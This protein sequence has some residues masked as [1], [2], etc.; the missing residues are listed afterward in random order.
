MLFGRSLIVIAICLFFEQ[1]V[2][3]GNDE[4]WLPLKF[5]IPKYAKTQ[6]VHLRILKYLN[7]L[8]FVNFK[9]GTFT[10]TTEYVFQGTSIHDFEVLWV[11]ELK[12]CRIFG[13]IFE[14]LVSAGFLKFR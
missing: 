13:T 6:K 1:K 10:P 11:Q 9:N 8:S 3:L 12:L 7:E 2:F 5:L 4:F 14:M